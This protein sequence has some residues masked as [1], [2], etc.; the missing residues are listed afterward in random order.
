MKLDTTIIVAVVTGAFSSGFTGLIQFLITR[1]DKK[2]SQEEDS[3]RCI[4]D[5]VRGL[6]HDRLYYLATKYIQIGSISK[7]DYE[8]L[9]EYIYQ[10]YKKLGGNGT[11]D[12]L[13]REVEKLP[14]NEKEGI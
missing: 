10:P 2:N 13:M 12:K 14:L 1:H 7:E 4:S 6:D 3:L 8:N 11:G 5:A 9:N